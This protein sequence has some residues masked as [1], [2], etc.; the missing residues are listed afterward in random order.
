MAMKARIAKRVSRR[1]NLFALALG[2]VAPHPEGLLQAGARMATYP[3]LPDSFATRMQAI[4]FAAEEA[5]GVRAW[6]ESEG[7]PY[8]EAEKKL[9]LKLLG[10]NGGGGRG[11]KGGGGEG[12][13]DGSEGGESENIFQGSDLDKFDVLLREVE[14]TISEMKNLEQ[15]VN[16]GEDASARVAV[17]KA[18]TVLLEKWVSLKSSVY[19]MQEMAQF[20]SIVLEAIESML[21]TDQRAELIARLKRQ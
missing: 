16:S 1:E 7:C 13:E 20:Q 5:G 6:L 17:V 4:V 8:G 9:L 19:S 15:M 12:G 10:R 21:D 3:N 11:G 18:K 14:G 2:G